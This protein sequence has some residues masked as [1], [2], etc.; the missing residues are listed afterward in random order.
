MAGHDAV[1]PGHHDDAIHSGI[2]ALYAVLV[3]QTVIAHI[4]CRGAV[5][6][7]EHPVSVLPGAGCGIY[8]GAVLL[9]RPPGVD[10]LGVVGHLQH[11]RTGQFLFHLCPDLRV[12]HPAIL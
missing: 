2:I 11:D 8:I 3:G 6:H 10:L 12:S 5:V 4:F 7:H 1:A 9:F